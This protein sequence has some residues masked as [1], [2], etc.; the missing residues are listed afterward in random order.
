[1]KKLLLPLLLLVSCLCSYSQKTVDERIWA[2]WDPV[3]IDRVNT[4]INADY[5]SSQEKLTILLT[6]LARTDGILFTETFL[7]S[8]LQ[9][10][11]KNK[12]SKSLIKDLKNVRGLPLLYPEMDLFKVAEGH[13][14]KSGKSGNLGHQGFDARFKPLMQKYNAV[15]ENCAYGYDQAI[16]IA[17][18]LLIDKDVPGLG[19]RHNMLNPK[20][21]SI[22]VSIQPHKTY[23]FNCVM[24]F[25]STEKLKE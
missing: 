15:A 2:R 14:I 4:A 18:Q 20:F 10:E 6:N 25:G 21:N 8:F 19:H 24:D 12:Y 3:S 1:M 11:E 13:A 23:R 9:G 17:L 22:G 5:L 7:N 16:D